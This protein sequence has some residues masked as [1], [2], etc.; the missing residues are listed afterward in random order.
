[1]KNKNVTSF[2]LSL[3]SQPK[4]P[5]QIKPNQIKSNQITKFKTQT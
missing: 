3:Y 5:N 1:M 2:S 4:Q